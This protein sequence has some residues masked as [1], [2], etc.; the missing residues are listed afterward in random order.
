MAQDLE[1]SPQA[2]QIASA[3]TSRTIREGDL[4][5]ATTLQE[6]Q[7]ITIWSKQVPADKVYAHGA[8]SDNRQQGRDAF[9]YAKLH[10]TGSGTGSADDAITGD[11]VAVIT[12][13]E[14]RDVH[15]RYELG[16]LTSLAD[17]QS[18]NL[19]ERPMQPVVVPIA[20]EDQHLELRVIADANSDGVELDDGSAQSTVA[21]IHYTDI[22]V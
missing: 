9:M 19:T 14:Q 16:D 5:N 1:H 8:G 7:E 2:R 4:D 13:S 15:A 20:R 10:A 3:G 21:R 11:L 6:D 22:S 17:A 12:D 18:E